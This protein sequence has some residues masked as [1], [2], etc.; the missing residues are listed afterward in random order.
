MLGGIGTISA[1][2]KE[3]KRLRDAKNQPNSQILT[4]KSQNQF[5]QLE[6]LK[7]ET[8]SL[9]TSRI[10]FTDYPMV[11]WGMGILMVI[12]GLYLIYHISLGKYG[13]LF[14]EFREGY[15]L[16]KNQ[17]FFLKKRIFLIFMNFFL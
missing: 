17:Y 12:S 5:N 1:L 9:E 8:K 4:R 10:C 3:K 16:I 11:G 2:K 7:M 14:S 13:S 15:F 6:A